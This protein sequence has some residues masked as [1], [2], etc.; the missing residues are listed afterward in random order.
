MGTT[1]SQITSLTIVYSTVYS[2]ADQ[3]KHQSSASLAFVR[4]IHRW[5]VNSPHKGLVTRK[6]LPFDVIMVFFALTHRHNNIIA[7]DDMA[8]QGV[9]ALGA[10]VLAWFSRN[11]PREGGSFGG[12]I[13]ELLL[14]KYHRN[15][16][17]LCLDINVSRRLFNRES[18]DIP[19]L[20]KKHNQSTLY[21]E[22]LDFHIVLSKAKARNLFLCHAK[23]V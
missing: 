2:G 3:R 13:A 22:Y 4:G 9:R 11:I 18:I 8:T 14:Q 1:V 17:H 20:K 19:T 21:N 16:K 15:H 23:S 6:M 5:P 7:A 12:G 10:K